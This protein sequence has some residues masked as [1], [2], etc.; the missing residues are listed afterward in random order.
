[1]T[2]IKHR[3][4][5]EKQVPAWKERTWPSRSDAL[6]NQ[7]SLKEAVLSLSA[8]KKLE[9]LD[10][11]DISKLHSDIKQWMSG[12]NIPGISGDFLQT[13]LT[14]GTFLEQ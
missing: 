4:V 10:F 11:L 13:L 12:E 6:K 3:F 2:F 8:S 1:M 7:K 14:M 9:N 5:P